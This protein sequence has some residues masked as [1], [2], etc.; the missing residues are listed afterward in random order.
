MFKLE[1][2]RRWEELTPSEDSGVRHC[3]HC[4]QQVYF[5]STD[6]ETIGHARAGHCIAREMPDASDLPRVFVG[7]PVGLPPV[8]TEQQETRRVMLRERGIDDSI[9]NAQT[10]TR[11][12]PRCHYPASDWRISCR[13]CGFEMGRV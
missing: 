11:A 9:K 13:V 12:C 1:C 3:S 4:K 7:K 8:T 10:A 6:E 5:C 2:P